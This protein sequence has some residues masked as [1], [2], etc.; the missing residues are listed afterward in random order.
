MK[1]RI[2]EKAVALENILSGMDRT[3][4]AGEYLESLR[5]QACATEELEAIALVLANKRYIWM[6]QRQFNDD[7]RTRI[8]DWLLKQ[9]GNSLAIQA[10][11]AT[12]AINNTMLKA[13]VL[14]E[15]NTEEALEQKI[16]D[17]AVKAAGSGDP[18]AAF[19]VWIAAS[20]CYPVLAGQIEDFLSDRENVLCNRWYLHLA[21]HAFS[22][23]TLRPGKMFSAFCA[24]RAKNVTESTSA[25]KTLL[26]IYRRT[27][28]IALNMA[29]LSAGANDIVSDNIKKNFLSAIAGLDK[30]K[31]FTEFEA[32]TLRE[33]LD[34]PFYRKIN[35]SNNTQK[36]FE[37]EI[38]RFENTYHTVFENTHEWKLLYHA[39][40]NTISFEKAGFLAFDPLEPENI[41]KWEEL[42]PSHKIRLLE[43][44]CGSLCLSDLNIPYPEQWKR[45]MKTANR[46]LDK[47]RRADGEKFR[48]AWQ[49]A[50]EY[51]RG[52]IVNALIQ[53]GL[54]EIPGGDGR[55][56]LPSGNYQKTE[57]Q[58]LLRYREKHG[59]T[60]KWASQYISSMDN[61]Y[62]AF[63][64][65]RESPFS[66]GEK[67]DICMALLDAAWNSTPCFYWRLVHG[68]FDAHPDF[69]KMFLDGGEITAL[70]ETLMGCPG[71][72]DSAHETLSRYTMS[73]AEWKR[74]KEK[75]EKAQQEQK[76]L[77]KLERLQESTRKTVMKII[78]D[79]HIKNNFTIRWFIEPFIKPELARIATQYVR[80][81]DITTAEKIQAYAEIAN[82]AKCDIYLFRELKKIMKERP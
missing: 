71:L 4:S 34:R 33:I 50:W 48:E 40:P 20:G 52:N 39:V 63:T 17:V 2:K 44:R 31:T 45:S 61:A 49:V 46:L 7:Y 56:W 78:Q 79:A 23:G 12:L 59:R 30:E 65:V 3:R 26:K 29:L 53:S 43:Y 73:E 80:E 55:F 51:R 66:S 70:A 25:F 57:F 22:G 11:C 21:S 35:G 37:N 18:A 32:E 74:R 58:Y 36:F 68:L 69:L 82:A 81:Q 10:A 15:D 62:K 67:K 1:E 64:F 9:G 72:S 13:V 24:L 19:L 38:Q 54:M 6:D 60:P 14:G 77:E 76:D 8:L 16:L 5:G 75:A 41:L 47:I 28:I 42:K 27:E